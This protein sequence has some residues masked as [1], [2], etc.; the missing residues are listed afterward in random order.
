MPTQFERFLAPRRRKKAR[1]HIKDTAVM[2]ERNEIENVT[3]FRRHFIGGLQARKLSQ[4]CQAIQ[5]DGVLR[6]K[7]GPGKLGN[8]V[9]HSRNQV[10]I[11]ARE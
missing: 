10:D 9:E 4:K 5:E 1:E 3:A 2:A 11:S 6:L 8:A 7:N